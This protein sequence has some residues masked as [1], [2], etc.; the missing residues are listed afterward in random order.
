MSRINILRGLILPGTSS[1][2]RAATCNSVI[3]HR[4]A[5]RGT[6]TF[7]EDVSLLFSSLFLTRNIPET[8]V[9]LILST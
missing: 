4:S 1:G 9:R 7:D 5:L 3:L 6:L 8:S 2:I